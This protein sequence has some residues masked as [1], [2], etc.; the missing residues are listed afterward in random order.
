MNAM[1]VEKG[2]KPTASTGYASGSR[3]S[4]P[5]RSATPWLTYGRPIHIRSPDLATDQAPAPTI[6]CPLAV[7]AGP[8]RAAGPAGLPNTLARAFG[9]LKRS[10]DRLAL[11]PLR[12][13]LTF[14][15]PALATRK[16][17]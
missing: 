10:R 12:Y 5:R 16:S 2:N 9:G 8:E 17:E 4:G 1:G 3:P 15:L 13:S 6:R 14:T 7:R 11:L